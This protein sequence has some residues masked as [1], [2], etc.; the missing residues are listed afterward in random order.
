[1]EPTITITD[2]TAASL[3]FPPRASRTFSPAGLA[4]HM[5]TIPTSR[6]ASTRS[7]HGPKQAETLF[8][9]TAW[10]KPKPI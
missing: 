2:K 1:M 9:C 3:P 8:T 10:L 5:P 4:R 6:N 7:L